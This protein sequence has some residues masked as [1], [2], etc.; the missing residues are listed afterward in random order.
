MTSPTVAP[1]AVDLVLAAGERAKGGG[2][3]NDG[4]HGVSF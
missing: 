2:D 3:A 1:A 4:F